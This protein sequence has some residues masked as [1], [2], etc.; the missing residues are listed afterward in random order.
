MSKDST[1]FVNLALRTLL[2]I[3]QLTHRDHCLIVLLCQGDV[4]D[5]LAESRCQSRRNSY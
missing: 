5:L 4:R 1:L 3:Q 2:C